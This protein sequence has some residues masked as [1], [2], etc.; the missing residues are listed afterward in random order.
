LASQSGATLAWRRPELA[1]R[2][3]L[4]CPP[5]HCTVHCSSASIYSLRAACYSPALCPAPIGVQPALQPLEAAPKLDPP[6]PIGR[7]VGRRIGHLGGLAELHVGAQSRDWMK[8]AIGR[9]AR[10]CSHQR[11]LETVSRTSAT[12]LLVSTWPL[13]QPASCRTAQMS[14][15]AP[16]EMYGFWGACFRLAIYFSAEW[17]ARLCCSSSFFPLLPLL[18]SCALLGAPKIFV[19]RHTLGLVLKKAARRKRAAWLAVDYLA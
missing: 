1:P 8:W 9:W 12:L 17:E 19:R 15:G 18:I 13:E 11:L 7:E 2:W 4:A 6:A 3:P 5:L 14:Y 16:M 10:D